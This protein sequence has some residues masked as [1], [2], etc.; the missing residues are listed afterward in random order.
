MKRN[1]GISLQGMMMYD[2]RRWGK[3]EETESV[4]IMG[5]NVDAGKEGFYQRVVP[6]TSR[7]GSR[8]VNR[9]LVFVPIPNSE[10]K[11]LPSFDQNPGW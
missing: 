10:I 1:H 9:K 8:M 11:R 4:P 7:I 5:M 2:V 3:Y 6:N